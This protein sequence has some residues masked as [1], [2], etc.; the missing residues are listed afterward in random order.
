MT[1]RK[2]YR[3]RLHTRPAQEAWLRRVAGRRRWVWNTALA[4]QQARHGRGEPYANY[5]A[6]AKQED[7]E[8]T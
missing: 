8:R 6:M 4:E 1:I 5:V 3:Y 2:D 7:N